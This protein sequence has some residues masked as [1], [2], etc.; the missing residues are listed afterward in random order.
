MSCAVTH[1]L[2]ALETR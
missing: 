2:G 1:I